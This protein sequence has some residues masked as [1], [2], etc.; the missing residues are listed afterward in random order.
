MTLI[1]SHLNLYYS[2]L[3]PLG[4]MTSYLLYRDKYMKK[5]RGVAFGK[6]VEECDDYMAGTIVSFFGEIL[7]YGVVF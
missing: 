7:L 4:N 6:A 2:G 3:I 1:Q 5:G